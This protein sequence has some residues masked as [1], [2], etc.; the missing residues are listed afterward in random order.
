MTS[1]MENEKKYEKNYKDKDYHS[2]YYE[3]KID[4]YTTYYESNKEHIKDMMRKRYLKNCEKI[5]EKRKTDY[6]D[7]NVSKRIK[8]C[9]AKQYATT[10][11]TVKEM[12]WVKCY[13][14]QYYDKD[15][16]ATYYA[17]HIGR[18]KEKK[19]E[20]YQKNRAKV[21]EQRKKEYADKKMKGTTKDKKP[22]RHQAKMIEVVKKVK[23][24]KVKSKKVKSKKKVKTK[25]KSPREVV[26]KV[27]VE[28]KVEV[29]VE[30]NYKYKPKYAGRAKCK[31]NYLPPVREM[32]GWM[33]D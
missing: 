27:E 4:Y 31:E 6:E 26:K 5:L 2:K 18:I 21:L 19:K 9:S 12:H 30:V 25:K 29:K 23:S 16:H 33:I 13:E 1:D 32:L 8:K 20:L 28:K 22:P 14:K 17:T 15:Y 10:S 24:K 11:N 7:K 3:S